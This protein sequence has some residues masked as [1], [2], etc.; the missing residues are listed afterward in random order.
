LVGVFLIGYMYFGAILPSLNTSRGL[1][2]HVTA[3]LTSA[4]LLSDQG[5]RILVFD[6]GTSRNWLVIASSSSILV[7][8]AAMLELKLHSLKH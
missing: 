2:G 1:C 5:G 6:L 8:K 7:A 4:G 3:Q